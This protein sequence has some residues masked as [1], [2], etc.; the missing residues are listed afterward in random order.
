M[1]CMHGVRGWDITRYVR[2]L[3]LNRRYELANCKLHEGLHLLR[4][5]RVR[6]WVHPSVGAG[7]GV[8]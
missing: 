4:R 7:A 8:G 3:Y 1:I 6:A 5:S 2:N